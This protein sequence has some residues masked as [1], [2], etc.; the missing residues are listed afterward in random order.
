MST[1]I[2]DNLIFASE[3]SDE[4]I[5]LDQMGYRVIKDYR[6]EYTSGEW[7][8]DTTY[9][10]IPGMHYD[11]TPESSSSRIRVICN[12]PFASRNAAH[13]ISHWIFYANGT[14]IGKHSVSGNHIEDYCCYTWDFASW[15]TTEGRV[16]YQLR[17]YANDNNE[18]RLYTTRYWE[19]SGS[20]QVLY[21]QFIIQE[22][23]PGV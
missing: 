1:L 4:K 20:Q 16:G 17:S 9:A 5:P 15:G 11:Y 6:Q 12:I 10:W 18:L 14:E 3:N 2:T 21:G 19:G 7:N 13:A 23:L 22:Y 8:P